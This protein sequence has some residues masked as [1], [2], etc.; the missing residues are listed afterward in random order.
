MSLEK[1]RHLLRELQ[2]VTPEM[3]NLPLVL[4][5]LPSNCLMLSKCLERN[6]LFSES[7]ILVFIRVFFSFQ[8]NEVVDKDKSLTRQLATVL[9]DLVLYLHRRYPQGFFDLFKAFLE[10]YNG[11]LTGIVSSNF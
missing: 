1:M 6:D 8:L 4:E 9:N 7:D 5:K 3:L 10:F 2:F 11:M